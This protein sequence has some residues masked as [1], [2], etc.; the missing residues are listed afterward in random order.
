[1]RKFRFYLFGLTLGL[2]VVFFI[3]NQKGTSCSYFPNDRVL[4][5][6]LTKDLVYTPQFQQ[7]LKDFNLNEKFVKDSILTK[8]EI[9]FSRS[10][11]QKQPC[12]SYL[13]SY[14]AKKPRF[15]VQFEKCKESANF[16]QIK[17]IK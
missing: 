14:P 11:A 2:V 7:E 17:K 1:M 5:E 15:E 4:A 3:L 12:P 8:G 13:L 6:T 16:I 9:D 10:D